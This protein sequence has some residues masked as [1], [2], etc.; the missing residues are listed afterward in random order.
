VRRFRKQIE[1]VSKLIL[2]G[3]LYDSL[4]ESL[5][6]IRRKKGLPR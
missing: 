5:Q 3:C 4:R 1:A 6:A 2:S